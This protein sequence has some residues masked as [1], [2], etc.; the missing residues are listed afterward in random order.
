L[1]Q[2]VRALARWQGIGLWEN[3]LRVPL[4]ACL[5]LRDFL[6]WARA[7]SFAVIASL[8]LGLR[9]FMYLAAYEMRDQIIQAARIIWR[10]M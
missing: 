5:S 4:S 8:Q 1:K 10:I 3:L 2:V 6:D 7:E 9:R